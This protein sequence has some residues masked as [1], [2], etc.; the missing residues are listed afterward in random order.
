MDFTL[1]YREYTPKNHSTFV[2]FICHSTDERR[3]TKK[4]TQTPRD[5]ERNET[6]ICWLYKKGPTYVP[7]IDLS[8]CTLV[9]ITRGEERLEAYTIFPSFWI[10]GVV[11]FFDTLCV[12]TTL[13][14]STVYAVWS[15][16]SILYCLVWTTNGRAEL[17]SVLSLDDASR[18]RRSLIND[19]STRIQDSSFIKVTVQVIFIHIQG[20]PS[21]NGLCW[22]EHKTRGQSL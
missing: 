6:R 22:K 15:P 9:T 8:I 20:I 7:Q 12:H 5:N 13:H 19:F 10:R 18:Q 3:S 4:Y 1:H 11:V 21:A 14:Y 2:F 16:R 17:P